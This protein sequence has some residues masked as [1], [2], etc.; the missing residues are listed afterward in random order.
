MPT[1]VAISVP[2]ATPGLNDACLV[3]FT[4]IGSTAIVARLLSRMTVP[5]NIGEAELGVST[6][7]VDEMVVKWVEYG[8]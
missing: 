8:T 5:A 1:T 6:I 4:V 7:T 2:K 3:S